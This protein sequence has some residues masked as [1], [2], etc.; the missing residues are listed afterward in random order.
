[1]CAVVVGGSGGDASVLM[2][3]EGKEA[4]GF[5]FRNMNSSHVGLG[6]AC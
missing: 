5:Q 6:W 4:I 2:K 3:V 1:V